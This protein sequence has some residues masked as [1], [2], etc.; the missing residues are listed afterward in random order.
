VRAS[1]IQTRGQFTAVSIT[2]ADLAASLA[3]MLDRPV[4]NLTEIPGDFAIDLR[5]TPDAPGA[6]DTELMRTVERQLGLKLDARK[7]P[8]EILRIDHIEKVPTGN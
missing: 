8:F 3:N 7:L 5:W 2:I 1:R 6:V 4:V